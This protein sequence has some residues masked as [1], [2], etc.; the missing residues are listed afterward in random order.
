MRAGK[1]NGVALRITQR[2][3]P[4]GVLTAMTRFNDLSFHLFGTRNSGVEVVEFKPQE[5]AISGRDAWISETAMLML[6]IPSVQL[7]NQPAVRNEPLIL[8]AAMPTLTAK[9]T[10]IPATAR[11]N[12]AHANKGLET[13]IHCS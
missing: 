3:F 8:R 2:A 1:H 9:E 10:L 5:H 11:F 6:D 13:Y 12:I 4:V 7:K